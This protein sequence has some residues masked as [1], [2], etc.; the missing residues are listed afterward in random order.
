MGATKLPETQISGYRVRK[1]PFRLFGIPS[2]TSHNRIMAGAATALCQN[3][4]KAV[5]K[6]FFGRKLP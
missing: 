2:G 5:C 6:G 3:H 4:G 1:H